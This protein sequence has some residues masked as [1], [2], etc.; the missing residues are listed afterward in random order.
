MT[1]H[2]KDH[3]KGFQCNK[4]SPCFP[5]FFLPI[6]ALFLS[7]CCPLLTL[8]LPYSCLIV[9]LFLPYCCP[10]LVLL[11]LTL[12]IDL[13]LC[14]KFISIWWF[15]IASWIVSIHL[16]IILSQLLCDRTYDVVNPAQKSINAKQQT[17]NDNFIFVA[18]QG[19]LQHKIYKNS[20][21]RMIKEWLTISVSNGVFVKVFNKCAV[22]F[23]QIGATLDCTISL[24]SAKYEPC[25][26]HLQKHLCSAECKRFLINQ[27][28][29]MNFS[30]H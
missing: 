16:S 2:F 19:P 11:V 1:S 14:P 18:W 7:Y 3:N 25:R 27:P 10:V 17:I 26:T 30:S 21:T 4:K 22:C 23:P 29:L 20:P 5:I 9:A 8:L 6:V 28:C 13:Y 15:D 24:A 12:V